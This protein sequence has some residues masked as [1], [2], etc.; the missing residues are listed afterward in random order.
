MDSFNSEPLFEINKS[1]YDETTSWISLIEIK[2]QQQQ[3][4]ILEHP[5]FKIEAFEDE[6]GD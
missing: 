1:I 3:I 2:L 6:L 4:A 5:F